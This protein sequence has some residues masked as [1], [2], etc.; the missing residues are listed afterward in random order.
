[1]FGR[2][3]R[4]DSIVAEMDMMMKTNRRDQF[5]TTQGE[6]TWDDT[7][8]VFYLSQHSERAITELAL[9]KTI[10]TEEVRKAAAVRIVVIEGPPAIMN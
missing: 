9:G 8:L 3:D 10:P 6:V 2:L 5:K 4:E 7:W 1:M